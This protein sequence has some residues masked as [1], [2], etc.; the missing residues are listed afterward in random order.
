MRDWSPAAKDGTLKWLESVTKEI[1]AVQEVELWRVTKDTRE[2]R[3]VLRYMPHGLDVQLMQGYDFRR[4][5]LLKEA[6]SVE[7]RAAEWRT[8]LV[9]RG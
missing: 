5:E 8:A 2:L 3:C 1:P 7:V 4:T 6:P 9:E